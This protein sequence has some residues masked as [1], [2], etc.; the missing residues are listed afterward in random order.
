MEDKDEGDGDKDEDDDDKEEE[1]E[2]EEGGLVS[3]L[4]TLALAPTMHLKS[5]RSGNN[6]L[7]AVFFFS[8]V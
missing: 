8:A 6:S 3:T 1:E 7:L 5:W 2:E 4:P